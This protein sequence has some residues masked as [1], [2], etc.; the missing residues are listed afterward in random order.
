MKVGKRQ[1]VGIHGLEI[2]CMGFGGA[3]FGN[4]FATVAESDVTDCLV[5][6]HSLG[7]RYFDT[8]P[9]YGYGL[10]EQRYGAN[11]SRFKRDEFAIS[12][13]VGYSLI[14]LQ[15]NDPLNPKIPNSDQFFIDHP[16][17]KAVFDYSA[18]AVK[19]SLDAS[20]ERL[21]TDRLDIVYIHDPDEG[22]S[23]KPDLNPYVSSHFKE[24]MNGAYKVLDELRSQ[25]VVKAIGVG[26][27]QWQMLADFARA[28]D[29]DCFLLAGRYTLLE[30]D[31]LRGLL[32][33][34]ERKGVQI[35]IGGPYNSGI[36]V[37]GAV[38]GAYYNYS[39]APPH[40]LQKVSKIQRVCERYGVRLPAAALQ[41]PLA[42]PAVASVIPGG[43]TA[44]EVKA[45]TELLEEDIPSDFWAELK[46]ERLIDEEAP[47]PG[48]EIL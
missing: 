1:E 35:V 23:L 12:T 21:K 8:A 37:T 48:L 47:V 25:G 43:R 42:H 46:N 34:C 11:F 18:E 39:A 38:E 2:T 40:I 36:L 30:Q 27:N 19:K 7:I 45:N 28:G 32:S 4:L 20:M 29:F 24:A 9:L 13:K 44:L 6:A 22:V 15:E 3:P 14:P 10:S 33:D 17:F 31:S 5:T 16:P 41:F 26:M